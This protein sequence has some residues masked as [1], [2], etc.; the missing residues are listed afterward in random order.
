MLLDSPVGALRSATLVSGALLAAL[1]VFAGGSPRHTAA[2][3]AEKTGFK[4]TSWENRA[5][6]QH[7][8][9]QLV[10][11]EMT[12]APDGMI[13][14]ATEVGV[15]D[16]VIQGIA[17]LGGEIMARFDE[18]GYFR[19]RLP[20][21]QFSRAET[22]PGVLMALIDGGALAFSGAQ[23]LVSYPAPRKSKADSTEAARA[24]K[25]SIARVDSITNVLPLIPDQ[26]YGEGSPYV[27][28]NDMLSYDLQRMDPRFDGRGAMVAV[29]EY[30]TLDFLHPALQK[31]TSL[32]GRE[33]RKVAGV[34]TPFSYDPD[35]VSPEMMVGGGAYK[36]FDTRRVRPS[37]S[38]TVEDGQF[39]VDDSTFHAPDGSYSFGWYKAGKTPRAVI[40]DNARKLAWVDTDGDRSFGDERAMEEINE[41]YSIGLLQPLDSTEA[42]PQRSSNFAVHFDSIPGMLRIYE[43]TQGHQTMV[44]GVAA[45]NGI[46]GTVGAS[47]PEAQVMIIDA[48][49]MVWSYLESWIRAARDPRIDVVTSSQVGE[50]FISGGESLL[51]LLLNRLVEVHGK[52]FFA[53]AHNSGP[54]STSGGEA[55]TIPRVNSVGAYVAKETYKAHY[56]WDVPDEDYLIQY[57]SRGPSTNGG[58]KPDFVASVLSV[59]GRPCLS[60]RPERTLMYRYPDCYRLAGG[61]SSSSPHAAGVGTLLISTARQSG[62]PTDARHINWALRM[63][64]RFLENYPAHDQGMGLLVAV[65]SYELL[66]IA[67]ENDLHIPDIETRAPNSTRLAK[68]LRDPGF[69]DG[70]YEREGW[71]AGDERTRRIRLTRRNGPDRPV[72]YDIAWRGNNGT[73]SA[74][75]RSVELPLGS[76]VEVEVRIAPKTS[77]MHS[78]LLLLL[79][80]GTKVPMHNVL[81]TVVAADRF[82]SENDFQVSY[83]EK[84]PWPRAKS[85]FVDVPEGTASLRFDLAVSA[86]R[87][88]LTT[89]DATM[90]R[91]YLN[92]ERSRPYRYAS[93]GL[94]DFVYPDQRRTHVVADPEPGVMEISIAPY[95]VARVEN[96]SSRY[97]VPSE[98][99]LTVSVQR[100]TGV[101]A[102]VAEAGSSEGVPVTFTNLQAPLGDPRVATEVG[103]RRVLRATAGGEEI[104]MSYYI[105]VE[106]GT[107]TLRVEALA[108]DPDD[109]LTLYLYDC[110]GSGCALWD[111]STRESPRKSML[112]VKPRAGAWKVVI[113]AAK[114][115]GGVAPFTY[116]EI[117]THPAF[118]PAE[119][120]L[121]ATSDD[122]GAT[123]TVNA[124]FSP[125]KKP[126]MGYKWVGVADLFD[127]AVEKAERENPLGWFADHI[128]PYRPVRLATV[129]VTLGG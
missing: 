52:P 110:A 99:E 23:G 81:T 112:V 46:L 25:D 87:V 67:Q 71:K 90:D 43:G 24:A 39:I 36:S 35:F 75:R 117:L 42:E 28:M 14:F 65:R 118:G 83:G 62:L 17:A 123:F 86:G 73:F 121:V 13:L 1:L 102:A 58:A 19:A 91:S 80:P 74:T 92:R 60:L 61:T 26:A 53:S 5:I 30:G 108:D 34:I 128:P 124:E 82:I 21:K 126:R 22:T 63:G 31:A 98:F 3:I 93:D 119:A 100:A 109:E 96:D 54:I 125:F 47:A 129:V 122:E 50:V 72:R 84:V 51:A 69:G 107:A 48:G 103:A 49:L 2:Q 88:T 77:G 104:P 8:R 4:I 76:P 120:G 89:S 105:N 18:I 44:A 97:N 85:F 33:I 101:A 79:D 64:A 56:G 27:A 115:D 116:T 6:K 40:W 7:N 111:A 32:D 55:A 15:T 57:S 106:E 12:G 20:L 16:H 94:G 38:V 113:D 9:L 10:R 41:T 95:G 45:G 29:L 70:L 11:A 66:K 37:E 78:A 114:A 68:F 127:E 59:S